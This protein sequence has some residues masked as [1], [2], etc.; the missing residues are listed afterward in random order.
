MNRFKKTICILSSLCILGA[1]LTSCANDSNSGQNGSGSQAAG[2]QTLAENTA[3]L[4][5]KAEEIPLPEGVMADRVT[6]KNGKYYTTYVKFIYDTEIPSVEANLYCFDSSGLIYTCELVNG[7]N[8]DGAYIRCMTVADDGTVQLIL[9]ISTY[10]EEYGIKESL[11]K[12]NISAD[13]KVTNDTDMGSVISDQE[14]NDGYYLQQYIMDG[15]GKIYCSIGNKTVRIL[16]PDGNK[17]ADITADAKGEYAGINSMFLDNNGTP[18]CIFNDYSEKVSVYQLLKIDAEGKKFDLQCEM[19]TVFT[20]YDGSGDYMG[21]YLG[22][23]GIL[24]IRPD[25]TP[26][27]VANILSLGMD[28]LS[29]DSLAAQEDGSFLLSSNED[30]EYDSSGKKL[31]RIYPV[32]ASEI[33]QRQN[34]TLGC[35]SLDWMIRE[36]IADFNKENPDYMVYVTSYSDSNNTGNYNEA[37][38]KFNNE[39]LAGNI[40]DMVV[41]DSSMPV[42]SY[43]NKGLFTDLY[44][45][46]DSDSELK[47]ESFLENILK[48]D[49]RKGALYTISPSFSITTYVGKTSLIGTDPLLTTAKAEEIVN[50]LGEG[51]SMFRQTDMTRENVIKNGMNY[52]N[53]VDYQNGTCDFDNDSFANLL[54]LSKKYPEEIN[55]EELYESDPD[56]W[57]NDQMSLR[58]NK[59]LLAQ[60]YLSDFESLNWNTKG[61]FGEPITYVSFPT[62]SPATN[63]VIDLPIQ[64]SISERAA[65]K[66]GAWTFLKYI[67]THNLTETK[68]SYYNTNGERVEV[69]ETRILNRSYGFPVLK[70]D[71]EKIVAE[72]KKPRHE[73]DENGNYKEIEDFYYIASQEIKMEKMT[74]ADIDT[75]TDVITHASVVQKM[76]DQIKT[77]IDDE[78]TAFYAGTKSARETAATIQSRVSIYMSEQF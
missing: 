42:D 3:S 16:D 32:D 33:K 60:I 13:G 56:Y 22:D 51:A 65:N 71:F 74:E 39:L 44:Q 30:M 41:L 61:L 55:Y 17:I 34:I 52:S 12:M 38:T 54:E 26:E 40:P 59:T 35:F 23:A 75:I 76:N 28:T 67:L 7:S 50:G 14:Q 2:S 6:F 46:M 58:N 72:A 49:E 64:L 18:C 9:T 73:Y 48:A 57:T 21:Y 78:C 47:R 45:L 20:T 8:M 70:S 37:V 29:C 10:D 43:I 66:D 69:D 27:I 11:H 62:D 68:Y 25:G 4:N 5:F 1:G 19:P 63:A 31:L 77:I 53:F 15:S 24:G 36:L